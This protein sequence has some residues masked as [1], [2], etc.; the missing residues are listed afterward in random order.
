[1]TVLRVRT[2][3]EL[4]GRPL[5]GSAGWMLASQA[6]RALAQAAYFVLVARALGSGGFGAIA[7]ALAV[8]S[9]AMP[10]AGFG[11]GQVLVQRASVDPNA[12]RQAWGNAIA[13]T[14]VG[15]AILLAGIGVVGKLAV[16]A[17]PLQLLL[18]MGAGE[19]FFA[20]VTEVASQVFLTAERMTL[21]A[22]TGLAP[23]LARAIAAA[24]F[25]AA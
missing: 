6:T 9:V 15:G 14:A 13:V 19:F 23:T 5:A 16:P 24:A 4:L 20:R 25:V 7:A 17:L 2:M 8:V 21:S 3:R 11:M 1:M 22:L 10:F 12:L 18:L